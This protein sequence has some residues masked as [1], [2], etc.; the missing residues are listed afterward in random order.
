MCYEAAI[1]LADKDEAT[2][3]K[4]L[5]VSLE[6][7]AGNWYSRLTPKCIY[8]WKQLKEKFMLNFQGFQAALSTEEDFL[9]YSQYEKKTLPNFF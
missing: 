5:I 1:A 3:T 9:S 8:S 7:T 2:L 6:D 4:S